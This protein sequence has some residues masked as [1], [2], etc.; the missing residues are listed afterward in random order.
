M[1]F[2][3]FALS[4]FGNYVKGQDKYLDMRKKLRSAH[5]FKPYEEYVSE[6][7]VYSLIIA[8][9]GL[10]IGTM[11]GVIVVTRIHIPIMTVYNHDL[12]D[13]IHLFVPYKD[14]IAIGLISG[15]FFIFVGSMIYS[16]FIYYPSLQ[17]SIRKVKIDTQL[18]HAI[19]YM[20]ALSRGETNIT[21]IIRS[22]ANLPN[23][24]GEVSNDFAMI[25]R[26]TELLG[27]D[28]MTALRNVQRETPSEDLNAFLGN[29]ITIIDNGGDITDFFSMQIEN[30]RTKIKSEHTLFLDML[31]M[32]AE[33]YV[34][35]FV[36]GPL[37]II[38]VAATLGSM[39]GSMTLL[40]VGLTYVIVPLGSFMFIF[41][42]DLM[43]PKDEQII[44]NLD[45]KKVKEFI[46]IRKFEKNEQKLFEDYEKS[47]RRIYLKNI[48]RDPLHTFFEE[49]ALS[50]YI[51]I[52]IAI[53]ILAIPIT[54]DP[55]IL[56]KGYVDT[57]IYLTNYIVLSVM[58]AIIP[59]TIFYEIRS[60]KIWKIESAIPQF[61]RNLSIINETGL[62]LSES[63]RVMLR[64][65][66][67]PLRVHIERMFT[68]MSWG[69]STKE[70]F[71]RF[72]NMVRLNSLSRVVAL[73]TKASETSGDIRQVLNITSEDSNINLQLKKDKST[74][75][76]IYL[77]IIYISFAVFLY[78]IYT[79]MT[80]FLPQMAKGA[81]AG[82]S[83]FIKS[84]DLDFYK[85]YFY[86][87]A[88]IQA[89]FSGM[90]AGVLGE[91]NPRSGFKH[92]IILMMIAFAVFKLLV[93]V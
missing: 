72:A 59:Y 7:I 31:G 86:H 20:Y 23:V 66:R 52:P 18:P 32:I 58:I 8:F 81:A 77:I 1:N 39:K 93:Y 68:D 41:L 10:I 48:I 26:D 30:Y 34:T 2:S 51:S 87:T 42:I 19:V 76:L 28:F 3:Q 57:S 63:L 55:S 79:L 80:T 47:N 65:E 37:F 69:A 85:V 64:T 89:F 78:V 16:I 14:Y 92:S 11:I 74:N 45:L 61:L 6:A 50:F 44:G 56:F 53:L 27:I 40:L 75:M 88:L 62:S 84:F 67:G 73:I 15:S 5:M 70:A 60:H 22:V 4:K 13:F 43:L 83:T 71:T 46:G 17:A 36:A 91:G 21:E 49:P 29:L 33:T 12:A 24:Y 35:G 38:I 54:S 25:L 9:L 90:M 82:G